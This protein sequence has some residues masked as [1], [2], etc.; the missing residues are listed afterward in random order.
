MI[1]NYF[2]IA[3]RNLFRQKL[4]TFI[5]IGGLA[6][7][8]ACVLLIGVYVQDELSYD[9][10]HRQADDIYRITWMSSN[11]QTRTP[12]PLAQ[13]LVRDFPEVET[14]TS[15]SP[16][17]GAGLTKRTLSLRNLERDITHDEKEVISVD[18]TFFDVFSFNLI[19]GNKE[20]VLRDV[21]GIVLS[22]K[23]AEKYFGNED[24]IG[25]H[26]AINDDRNILVVEGVFENLPH[27]SH[28]HFEALISYVTLK[29]LAG[30]N[31]PYYTWA[32]F[33]HYNYIKLREG[34][35]AQSLQNQMMNWATQYVRMP[36]KEWQTAIDNGDHFALQPLTD[37]H[38]ESKLRWELE[39]NGSKD[40]VY[41]MLAAAILIL[42]VA[43]INFMN[44][45][46]AKSTER[47]RE[48]GVRKALG[49]HKSQIGLQFVG[50]TLL[51]AGIAMLITGLL[52][53]VMLPLF[54][55]ITGKNLNI[56]Y[57]ENPLFLLILMGGTLLS[58]L[59]AALYPS[60]YLSS[61]EPVASLKGRGRLQPGGAGFRRVL[62][63]FQF[64][65]SMALLTGSLIIHHQLAFLNSKDL[66][67]DH[68]HI[69]V[70]P[71][72]NNKLTT[73]LTSIKST[74]G[75][76]SGVM[77][78]SASSSVPGGQF[79]QN[80][81]ALYSNPQQTVNAS[82]VFV[83]YDFFKTMGIDTISGR[84][85]SVSH[86]TDSASFVINE[87]TARQLGMGD[88]I[89]KEILWYADVSDAPIRGTVIGVVKDFNYGSLHHS[90]QPLIFYPLASY[91][92]LLI[93]VE[94]PIT[95]QMINGIANKW[96]Q[97]EDRF[98]FEYTLLEDD[99]AL[100]Y[101]N[102]DNTSGV[103]SG[104]S[105]ITILIACFGLFGIAS[106]S[107]SQRIKEV[108]IRKVLGASAGR[109]LVLLLRDFALLIGIAIAMAIP[110]T[111]WLADHWLRD[112]TY[113]VSVSW[114]DFILSAGLMVII[115]LFTVSYLTLK[116]AYG[117]PVDALKE[118]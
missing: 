72:K 76:V 53:E 50:E 35:N 115:A 114:V 39:P 16:L 117:N 93:K 34:S 118:E 75:E 90:I 82:E 62:I 15:L 12:H 69:V 44:L 59:I 64:V 57:V 107:Y 24:P 61:L 74:L 31:N 52:V 47:A 29:A 17:W 48:I 9:K 2:K 104:F 55:S 32:D 7:G 4:Y 30:E 33:G 56:N 10:F 105:I 88:A 6:L 85:F 108:G 27:H 116:A 67:F 87:A 103:L 73:Q 80:E 43:C 13:A 91:N 25:R 79:N 38:L 19:R 41:M 89:G 100:Q 68:E 106:L 113:R 21:G 83:D 23:L 37:I 42:V 66:G 45:S 99:I 94:G 1:T 51:A 22:Q 111:W 18:S 77:S 26:L 14:A 58:A 101:R 54:N 60:L 71:L 70:V 11:P 96:K 49:A 46:T 84:T 3:F 81:L 97:F 65:I 98:A 112:F 20:D 102:E 78:V 28:F 40:Y 109:I 8:M 92:N 86:V 36:E 95:E 63:V 110:I 5:N